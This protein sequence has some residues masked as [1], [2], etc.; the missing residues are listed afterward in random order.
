MINKVFHW[1]ANMTQRYFLRNGTF[2][3][4]KRRFTFFI[5]R[6][7]IWK[8]RL[9]RKAFKSGLQTKQLIHAWCGKLE[10]RSR[11]FCLLSNLQAHGKVWI[12]CWFVFLFYL[13]F[14]FREGIKYSL[15]NE[16]AQTDSDEPPSNLQFLDVLNEFTFK[17]IAQDKSGKTGV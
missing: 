14:V 1:P 3:Q 17:L 13:F 10:K 2:N 9:T 6:F 5:C 7:G 8:S 11:N 12:T 15:R 4:Q 16:D